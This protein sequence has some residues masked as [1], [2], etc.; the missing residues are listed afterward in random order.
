[1]CIRDSLKSQYFLDVNGAITK[2]ISND[3]ISK[4]GQRFPLVYIMQEVKV[5]DKPV[6]AR[7]VNFVLELDKVLKESGI[8]VKNYEGGGGV[9]QV[10]LITIDGWK[11]FFSLNVP[12]S[13]S[14]ENLN[15]ILS[16]KLKNKKFEYIDLRNGDKV[17]YK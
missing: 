14:I 13:Q 4:Y 8:K 9:D 12:L 7:F 11:V 2:E 16:K 3:E 1:M 5:G 15:L 6:S 10:N 17:Y